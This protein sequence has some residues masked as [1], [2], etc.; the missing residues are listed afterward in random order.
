[1][2]SGDNSYTGLTNVNAGALTVAH[3]N[4][5]GSAA[6]GTSVANGAALQFSGGVSTADN[7]TLQ[8]TGIGGTGALRN[9]S[10]T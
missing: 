1:T 4:A 8:G 3:A 10:G 5:L 7:L 9:L 2:L 6:V